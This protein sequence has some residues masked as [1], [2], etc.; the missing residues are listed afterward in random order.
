MS[1]DE[2]E[3]KGKVYKPS[4]IITPSPAAA[5]TEADLTAVIEQRLRQA[6]ISFDTEKTISGIQPDFIVYTPDGRQ[7]II[8]AKSSNH[9][10]V[11]ERARRQAEL[12]RKALG[13]DKAFIVLNEL[14]RDG[15][16]EDVLTLDDLLPAL[17]EELADSG[18]RIGLAGPPDFRP[19]PKSPSEFVFAAMP[20]QGEY[21]DVYFFAMAYAAN[22]VGAECKRV[23]CEEFQGN[24]VDEV[25]RLI[26]AASA[27]TVDL[28]EAK[29]NVL[30]EA[31]FAHALEKPCVHICSTPLTDLPFDVKQWKTT[32][33]QQGQ[34]HL[35]RKK[36]AASLKATLKR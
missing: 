9:P 17:R 25:K 4:V 29:P 19:K 12:Y 2:K 30:Y 36:L 15:E 20:F 11:A 6:N 22:S 3:S 1:E 16:S 18:P 23:D 21:D 34:T 26:K 28:S 32:E 5:R 14:K 13:A 24:I 31:G 10:G 27:V 33:Y 7:I 8:E 35:L